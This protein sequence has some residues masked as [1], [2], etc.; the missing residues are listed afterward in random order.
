MAATGTVAERERWTGT[1]FPGGLAPVRADR[2]ADAVRS[3]GPDVWARQALAPLLAT[4]RP[5][6][7]SPGAGRAAD[8]SP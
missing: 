4:G 8:W 6:P 3:T 7:A 2:A 1:A 5:I